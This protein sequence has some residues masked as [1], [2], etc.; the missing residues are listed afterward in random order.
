MNTYKKGWKYVKRNKVYLFIMIVFLMVFQLFNSISP[1]IVQDI[2]DDKLLGITG[3]WYQDEEGYQVANVKIS[4]EEKNGEKPY[5]ISY[6][7]DAFYINEGLV[8]EGVRQ[9]IGDE[10]VVGTTSY[11]ITKLTDKEKEIIFETQRTGLNSDLIFLVT[12]LFISIFASYIQRIA[13]AILTI[14]T[15]RDIRIDALSKIE[16]MDINDIESEP[17]G[18]MANR[19]LSD[20]VGV[21]SLYTST[22]NIFI[23]SL[24]AIIFSLIGMYILSPKMTLICLFLI[25]IMFFWIRKFIKQINYVAE[26]VNETNSQIIGRMNEIINGISILK[27]FN[28]EDMTITNF[29]NLNKQYVDEKLEEVDLHLTK[30]WNGINLFQG[31]SI[32]LVVGLLAFLN[33]KQI[34]FI[35]AGLIYAFYNYICKIIAPLNLLFHEFSNLEHSKIKTQRVFKILES[36][37]EDQTLRSIPPYKGN[38]KFEDV[39]FSYNEGKKALDKINIDIK[40]GQKVGFVGRSGSGKSTIINL[41]MRFNDLKKSDSGIISIDGCQIETLSKRTYRS[42]LGIILQE[43]ILFK[44]TL[45]SNIKFGKEIE[46]IEIIKTLELIGAKGILEKFNYDINKPISNAGVNLSLGEKQL[47]SLARVLIRDPSILIMD[48]ATA[49]IDTETESMINYALSYVVKNRTVIIVAHRLST[50]RDADQ[51]IML[52]DGKIIESGTHNQLLASGGKYMEMY[53]SQTHIN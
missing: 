1:L 6:I 28:S 19:V 46:N 44:G 8:K 35:Q 26:K 14:N 42:H 4:R 36:E 48:E 29:R 45:A 25:P 33:L 11:P 49:N 10:M 32:A 40:A 23:S 51:I 41:L 30:G 47:I 13:G 20:A 9:K 27:I 50:I 17:V 34:T 37:L 15:T 39:T 2:L 31:L 18:K 52:E 43:P 5:T 22:V 21:S 7:D 38:I 24:L 53:K 16:Y 3:V 12:V